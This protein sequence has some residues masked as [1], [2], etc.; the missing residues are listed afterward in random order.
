MIKLVAC[1]HTM[2]GVRSAD[3]PDLV[4]AN[5]ASTVP[6]ITDFDTTDE[7]DNKMYVLHFLVSD[8]N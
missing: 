8:T 1:G 7:F 6:V 4:P 3:F 2:G 5:P